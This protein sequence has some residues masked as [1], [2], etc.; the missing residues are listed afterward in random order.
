MT[1]FVIPAAKPIPSEVSDGQVLNANDPA[2]TQ[3][4]VRQGEA[5]PKQETAPIDERIIP[6]SPDER[7]KRKTMLIQAL[8]R[9]I[10][11]DRL[12][13][14]LPP[15]YYGEWC[16]NT[17]IDIDAMKTIG[18]WVDEEFASARNLHNDGGVGTVVADVIYMVTSRENKE[19]IDEIRMDKFMKANSPKVKKGKEEVEFES[20]SARDTGG[21]VPTFVESH[22]ESRIDRRDVEAALERVA[23]QTRAQNP[24][25]T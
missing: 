22:T 1:D 24:P 6:L 18:F 23:E 9:G 19:L 8:D 4:V 11:H 17:Q 7:A 20:A 5:Q 21:V 15:G 25:Q 3:T 14:D 10:V 13:V 16:R 2:R 12:A